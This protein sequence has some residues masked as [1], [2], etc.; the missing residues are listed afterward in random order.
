MNT[1][2][3]LILKNTLFFNVALFLHCYITKF[4]KLI[5]SI[6][7]FYSEWFITL[8]S[9]FWENGKQLKQHKINERSSTYYRELL[10]NEKHSFKIF[11][12]VVLHLI[13]R[14]MER[15][16]PMAILSRLTLKI[17]TLLSKIKIILFNNWLNIAIVYFF[18]RIMS[19]LSCFKNIKQ[20]IWDF[21]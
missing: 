8:T 4:L 7:S 20:M 11:C 2:P 18:S 14:Y 3:E 15:L 1:Y 17:P 21:K 13:I 16:L 6:F 19:R 5:W 12:Y 10:K 9:T